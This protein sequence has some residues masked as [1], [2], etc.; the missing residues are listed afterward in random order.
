MQKGFCDLIKGRLLHLSLLSFSNFSL[1]PDLLEEE[2]QD[3]CNEL[4]SE[5]PGLAE[6]YQKP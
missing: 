1:Y 2:T 6:M 4:T 5:T 3:R